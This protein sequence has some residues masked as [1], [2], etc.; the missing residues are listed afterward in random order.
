MAGRRQVTLPVV[1]AAP[2]AARRELLARMFAESPTKELAAVYPIL[3]QDIFGFGGRPG[4]N[5]QLVTRKCHPKEF[6][7]VRCQHLS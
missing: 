1:Q 2:L 5:L 6:D 3:L 4:W 7:Q